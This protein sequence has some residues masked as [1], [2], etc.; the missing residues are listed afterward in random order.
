MEGVENTPSSPQTALEFQPS[1]R[2]PMVTVPQPPNMHTQRKRKAED[3]ARPNT[4]KPV[5][6]RASAACRSCRARKVR[7][8]VLL[9]STPCTNCRLDGAECVIAESKR[10]KFARTAD[11]TTLLI[12]NPQRDADDNA[13]W[14]AANMTPNSELIQASVSGSVDRINGS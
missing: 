13:A 2:L 4:K 12:G 10:T 5:Q 11:G 3:D 1:C 8:D 7:C 14:N 9:K 6:K